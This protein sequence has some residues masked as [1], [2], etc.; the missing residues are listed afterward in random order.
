[1]DW[2]KWH[3]MCNLQLKCNIYV[4]LAQGNKCHGPKAFLVLGEL[5]LSRVV[6]FLCSLTNSIKVPTHKGQ[7]ITWCKRFWKYFC[8]ITIKMLKVTFSCPFKSCHFAATHLVLTIVGIQ[9][10]IFLPCTNW[11]HTA[12]GKPIHISIISTNRAVTRKL[13]NKSIILLHIKL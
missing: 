8:F 4:Y 3:N 1:M 6:Q 10:I 12:Y 11:V 7:K 5:L 2:H 9:E 13:L